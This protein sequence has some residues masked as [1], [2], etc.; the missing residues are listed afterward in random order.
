MRQDKRLYFIFISIFILILS[1]VSFSNGQKE[2]QDRLKE[3]EALLNDDI[4][5]WKLEE[6]DVSQ[7]EKPELDDSSWSKIE[8]GYELRPKVFWLRHE[9]RVPAV[10]S[11]IKIEASP[12]RLNC[13]FRGLGKLE[14][15]LFLDG[16]LKEQFEIEFGNQVAQE[17][18]E[19][20]LS[21]SAQSGEK[22]L[23]AFRFENLGR[24]P[25][26]KRKTVEPGT[27]LQIREA[28]TRS[29]LLL[30][31]IKIHKPPKSSNH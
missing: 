20:I 10:F 1:S 4:S 21:P 13:N 29:G 31:A 22:I 8:P 23:I 2:I 9:F 5:F 16:L 15:K 12:I 14:G 25:L 19:F 24:L 11:G 6:R 27:F 28:L 26:L 3:I 30:K 18:K 7:G 17:K